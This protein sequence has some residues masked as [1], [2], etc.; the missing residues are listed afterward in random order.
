MS[1]IIDTIVGLV[2]IAVIFLVIVI[3]SLYASIRDEHSKRG[4]IT[5]I[6]GNIVRGALMIYIAICSIVGLIIGLIA[7]FS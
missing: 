2:L 1:F 4:I 5:R 6:T 7:I 3:Y